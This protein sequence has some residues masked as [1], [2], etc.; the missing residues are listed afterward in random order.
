MRY[1][2]EKHRKFGGGQEGIAKLSN[3]N[4]L[5]QQHSV[6]ECLDLARR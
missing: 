4:A 1:F 5:P 6:L 2:K 3:L